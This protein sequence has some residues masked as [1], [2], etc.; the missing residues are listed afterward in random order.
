MGLILGRRVEALSIGSD[1][2]AFR[3]P[4]RCLSLVC[5]DV[6]CLR[7]SPYC[8]RCDLLVGADGLH[9]IDVAWDQS[10]AG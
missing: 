9:V 4:R 8:G 6:R 7:D 3:S 5:P 1:Q 2:A 10:C